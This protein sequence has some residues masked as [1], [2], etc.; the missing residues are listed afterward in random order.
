MKRP[1]RIDY[2]ADTI[3]LLAFNQALQVYC[4]NIEHQ[5]Q[6]ECLINLTKDATIDELREKIADLQNQLK[7]RDEE[8]RIMR[9]NLAS[10]KGVVDIN[11]RLETQLKEE[12]KN[13]KEL[14]IQFDLWLGSDHRS[15]SEKP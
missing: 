7:E 6:K 5:L 10:Y 9:I 4:D 13:T 12:R 2:V 11:K 1:Q 15:I 8:I 14:M 3:G